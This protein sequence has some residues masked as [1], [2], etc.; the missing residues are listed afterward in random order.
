M[1]VASSV[2]GRHC[3]SRP[4]AM[5]PARSSTRRCLEMAGPLMSNGAE[6]SL[7]VAGPVASRARI[8]RRVGS[9][10]AAK[11]VL[12][13]SVVMGM[14]PRGYVTTWLYITE[15][16]GCQGLA[17]LSPEGGETRSPGW[18]PGEPEMGVGAEFAEA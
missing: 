13:V 7:T 17:V 3:A 2:R 4:R 12:R 14:S 5:R 6:S 16:V 8:A 11:V 15:A 10:R 1:G 9:A 18:N